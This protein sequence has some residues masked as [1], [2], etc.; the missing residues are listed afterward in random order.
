[1]RLEGAQLAVVIVEVPT[2]RDTV[3]RG[4][5]RQAREE[6]RLTLHRFLV[7]EAQRIHA[8]VSPVSEHGFLVVA[9]RGSLSQAPDAAAGQPF[10]ERARSELGIGIEVGVGAG[11]TE[12]EA[13]ARARAALGRPAATSRPHSQPRERA[14]QPLVPG[15]RPPT[16]AA[17]RR[18]L[19][20]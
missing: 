16:G 5:P 19:D 15:P 7:Q 8:A 6:L 3:R 1:R 14:P 13:E 12:L 20:T 17:T 2:L 9:T 4:A 11:R 10:V 18:G